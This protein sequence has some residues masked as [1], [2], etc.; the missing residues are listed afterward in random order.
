MSS[1]DHDESRLPG[2]VESL[3]VDWPVRE[4]PAFEDRNAEA[5]QARLAETEAGSTPDEL[6]AAPLPATD[7]EG[8]LST[9]AEVAAAADN[10][11]NPDVRQS[12]PPASGPPRESAPP[13]SLADLARASVAEQG[14]SS[15]EL[16]DIARES[17]SLASRSRTSAPDIAAVLSSRTSRPSAPPA[18]APEPATAERESPAPSQA[19]PAPK[20]RSSGPLIAGGIA[21]LAAAAAILIVVRGHSPPPPLAANPDQQ[22]PTAAAAPAASAAPQATAAPEHEKGV[23]SLDQLPNGKLAAADKPEAPAGGARSAAQTPKH[24]APAKP[25][26]DKAEA[27]EQPTNDQ[28]KTEAP[29]EKPPGMKPAEGTTNGLPDKPSTGAV[30][31]AVGAVLGSARACVAGQD[32]PSHAVIV[33][34]SNGRVKSVSVSGPAAGTPAAGCIRAA[35]SQARVQPFARSRFSVGTPVRPQ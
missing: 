17:L 34:G 9:A 24:S 28:A 33:F 27:K 18:S 6:L 2:R 29:E 26:N 3:L 22:E 20:R 32:Q 21:L 5:I 14:K 12:P 30:A 31:V 15:D 11:D 23:L 10:A 1:P 25:A 13:M 19:T 16:S 8:P 7:D 35:L 4:D